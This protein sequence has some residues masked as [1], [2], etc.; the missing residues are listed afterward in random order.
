MPKIPS[1]SGLD[2]TLALALDGYEFISKRCDRHQSNIFQT[3]LLFQKTICLRGAEAAK[4]F[5]DVEKFSRKGV[6]PKRIQK[7]LL[8]EGGVQGTDGEV[9]RHRKQMFMGL[10]SP[11]RIEALA[12][13]VQQQW[14]K[15]AENWEKRDRVAL[16]S[17]ANE[18]LSQAVC[19]WSGVPLKKTELSAKTR[20]LAAM[21]DGSGAVGPRHWRGRLGRKRAE[22]WIRDLIEKV[23]ARQLDAHKESALYAIAHHRDLQGNLLAKQIAAVE[24]LNVLR[25]TVAVAR[26]VA[27]SALA[28]HEHPDYQQKLKTGEEDS[29]KQ[30]VQEVRRFYPFFPFAAALARYSFDWQ[31]YSFP[32]DTRVLLDLYGTNRD[33]QSWENPDLFQ[34]E[35]FRHWDES[36]F[37]FIPQGGGDYITN[38]RCAGEW[39]T[40]ALMSTTLRFLT[41]SITY[42]VPRQNLKT[43]LS[44]LPAIPKSRFV[45]SNVRRLTA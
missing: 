34:P 35:R 40:I 6:A 32:K 16:F 8:G 5:Y 25:P 42:D 9:H 1:D 45:I 3:R 38:H 31:G 39:I 19:D 10:M 22:A 2:S 27:F 11:E 29:L 4:V 18:V 13:L 30:F 17:E 21:I 14:M 43:S 26:Y 37:N 7:T 28:L 44:R 33:P 15:R 20:D 12:S 36:P 41:Q 23:R 24:L